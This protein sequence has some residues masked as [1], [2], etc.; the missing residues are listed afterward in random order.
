MSITPPYLRNEASHDH[1]V[2]DY[3]DWHVSLGR[4][5]RALKLWWVL[6]SYGAEGIRRHIREHIRLAQH[7]ATRL[8]D[9]ARFEIV[10][11]TPF[12]LVCFRHVDGDEATDALVTSLN[13][14]GEV[15]LTPTTLD[16]RR[17][18]R[19]SIGQSHTE[20]RHVDRLWE[21]ID[22]MA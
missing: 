21:L 5:F 10:A 13:D 17:V 1:T 15:Y 9:D 11:P 2:V 6:R 19:V 20:N 14:S 4:R 8:N 3:R 22:S 7:L 18:I 12:S 16:G